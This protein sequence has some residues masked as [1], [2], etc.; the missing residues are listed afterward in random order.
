VPNAASRT[1][2][3]QVL[4]IKKQ[5][6]QLLFA[7]GL[8]LGGAT[9]VTA[10]RSTLRL[11]DVLEENLGTQDKAR[12]AGKAGM[13]D[14]KVYTEDD[15]HSDIR[16]LRVVAAFQIGRL[17]LPSMA[18]GVMAVTCLTGAHNI[19]NNR[20]AGLNAA[21]IALDK[22]M[23]EYRERVREEFGEDK[24][25]EFRYGKQE[26][27]TI[28]EEANGPK[29]KK[30]KVA[31]P[32]GA[33]I[34]ARFFDEYSR[35]WTP[36]NMTNRTFVQ[37]QQNWAN[38]LLHSRGHLFLNEVYDML[39][40][41]RTPEGQIVGWVMRGD[42]DKYVDFGIFDR[43]SSAGVHDF[44]FG[45]EQNILLDFNVDGPVLELFDKI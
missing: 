29:K 4:K 17:Y 26:V 24:D 5:S 38:D 12:T 27:S 41:E 19:Q 32:D 37:C 18:L 35:N 13:L 33:S 6:P 3:R 8:V 44:M 31:G 30:R 34:Y 11:T 36:N 20:I 21:Y 40:L 22:G 7:A 1:A 15:A 10:C 2:A 43:T 23:K 28:T 16:K 42:G 45:N 25:R 9:I 14:G 39:G